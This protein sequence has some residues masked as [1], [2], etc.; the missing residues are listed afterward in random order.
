VN[1]SAVVEREARWAPYAAA[2]GVVAVITTFISYFINGSVQSQAVGT[3]P[4][5]WRQIDANLGLF[6][7]AGLLGAL[8][9]FGMGL[10]LV[11]LFRAAQARTPSMAGGLFGLAV[12]GPILYGIQILLYALSRAQI[13]GDYVS[14]SAGIGDIYTLSGNVGDDN[15][16]GA[17]SAYFGFAGAIAFTVIVIYTALWATRTGLLPRF[18]GTLG[19]AL[20]ASSLLFSFIAIPALSVWF[21]YVAAM[22]INRV[23]KGRP[24][25]WDA[26]EAMAPTRPGDPAPA[27]AGPAP[28]GVIEGDATE[29]PGVGE[30]NSN[31][32]RRERAKKRKRKRRR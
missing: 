25:A 3:L 19:M 12:G 16:L 14:Q 28:N 11:F 30:G 5:L 17:L 29:I 8:G 26:G 20:A 7:L 21:G 15:T 18:T 31:A 1:P 22:F 4:E 32:A 24:P 27:T 13:A 9:M 23:P 6:R 2:A 10:I